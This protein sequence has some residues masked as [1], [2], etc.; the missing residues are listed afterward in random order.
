MMALNGPRCISSL[1]VVDPKSPA[2]WAQV[3]KHQR[4]H[5][6]AAISERDGKRVCV[7]R[8]NRV[9]VHGAQ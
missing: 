4:S 5:L 3:G 1:Q 7:G 9:D 6:T 8:V 2:N